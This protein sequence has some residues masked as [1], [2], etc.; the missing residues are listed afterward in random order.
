MKSI[1]SMMSVFVLAA[2]L[3]TVSAHEHKAPR[4][5]T[6]IE[7]G[8][9]HGQQMEFVIDHNNGKVWAYILKD[10][11]ERPARITQ[12]EIVLTVHKGEGS[13]EEFAVTLT[14]VANELSGE[15][16]GDTSEFA[17]QSDKLKT[18]KIFEA[19]VTSVSVKG[20]EFKNVK[21]SF[22]KKKK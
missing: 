6:L 19:T 17:G 18:A 9:D 13:A 22:P 1:V 8:D 21:F 14:A 12:K 7:L 2:M 20:Q 16:V 3:G 5:G 10:H 15:K 4:G 11:A